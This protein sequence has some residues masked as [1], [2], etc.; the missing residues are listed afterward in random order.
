MPRTCQ[1]L[2]S[3]TRRAERIRDEERQ[4][5]RRRE[6]TPMD[7]I[8]ESG[9]CRGRIAL[10]GCGPCGWPTGPR[11]PAQPIVP[12]LDHSAMAKRGRAWCPS[13]QLRA[14]PEEFGRALAH[15][16]AG[17]S[18]GLAAARLGRATAG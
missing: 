13:R 16:A 6:A 1:P 3:W 7:T 8:R 17:I 5:P 15:T 14:A 10:R 2:I 9:R 11:T 12:V 18:P 4:L